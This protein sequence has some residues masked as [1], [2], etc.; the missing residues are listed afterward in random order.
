[1]T[2]I[3]LRLE[4]R[5]DRREV[6]LDHLADQAV[7]VAI[8]E[9]RLEHAADDRSRARVDVLQRLDEAEVFGLRS[10]GAPSDSASGDVTRRPS[11]RRFSMPAAASSIIELR[12]GAVNHD[13][14][15][16]D[17]LQECQRRDQAVE[18]VAQHRA[19]DL[20]HGE[21]RR[22]ELREA[23][24]VLLDFLRAAHVGKQAHDGRA[25]LLMRLNHRVTPCV[26]MLPCSFR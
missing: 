6:D 5:L 13:R 24:E 7:P 17:L 14:R 3:E 9:L 20:D 8:E 1:M 11:T 19:A 22:V 18:I 25:Q 15:Q 12:S 23:L 21:A 4:A 26:I 16:A 2:G 10:P